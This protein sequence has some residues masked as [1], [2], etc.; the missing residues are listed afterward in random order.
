VFDVIYRFDPDNPNPSFQPDDPLEARLRLEDGNREFAHLLDPLV[1]GQLPASHVMPFTLHDF[2]LGGDD[3]KA[4]TQQPFAAVLGCSDA[5]APT[6]VIF[7]QACNALFVV[8][9]AGN[10]LGSECLGSI[11]YA[12]EHLGSIK[13]L[14]VLGHSGCGAVTAAVDAFLE[15]ARYLAVASTHALRA[16]VDRLFPPVRGAARALELNWGPDVIGQPGYRKA[17]IETAV[18]VNAVLTASTLRQ[19]FRHKMGAGLDVVFGV[20]DLASRH[21]RL[22]IAGRTFVGDAEVRLVPPP[23]DPTELSQLCV[24]LAGSDAVRALLAGTPAGN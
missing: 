20:Y 3:N 19:E 8:R 14:V 10:V 7:N 13:L 22:P 21:V 5:R 24:Q 17:L 23:D 18:A 11:D 6:E 12:V 16:I 1:A 4:P 15:P 9:V 2:G